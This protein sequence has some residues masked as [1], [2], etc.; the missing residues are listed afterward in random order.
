MLTEVAIKMA[1]AAALGG[2][3]GL[4]REFYKKPAGLRTNIL[5]CVGSTLFTII[6]LELARLFRADAARVAAQIVT[7]IG[8]IGAG[9]IFREGYTVRGITT[10]ATIWAAAAVGMAVGRQLYLVAGLGALLVF[11]VLEARPFTRRLDDLFRRVAR[12]LREEPPAATAL[13]ENPEEREHHD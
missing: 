2:I 6:S 3:I 11:A 9:V 4:E 8:F 1:L 12:E 7:G 5:I 10:A 13:R